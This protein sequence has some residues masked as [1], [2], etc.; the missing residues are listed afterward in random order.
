VQSL[1]DFNGFYPRPERWPKVFGDVAGVSVNA[2]YRRREVNAT[3]R[4]L[5]ECSRRFAVLALVLVGV[6]FLGAACGGSPSSGVASIGS[7]TTSAPAPTPAAR[8]GG[9][10]TTEYRAALA[11]VTCMRSHGVPNFPDPSSNG[12]I[13]VDFAHGGKGGSP[14]SAGINRNSPRYISADEACRHLLPGGTPTPAQNQQALAKGLKLAQCMRSHGVPNYP[15]PNPTNPNVVHL[16]GVDPSSPQFQR[17]QKVCESLV[18]G[19]GS[20]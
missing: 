9:N 6:G 18:P 1:E 3:T 4:C 2:N 19:T 5:S 17:A 14:A 13:N 8:S 7:T 15:D 12:Q 11:Y 10:T 16:N 20:K